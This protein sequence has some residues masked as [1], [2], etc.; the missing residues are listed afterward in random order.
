VLL[1]GGFGWKWEMLILGV[2]LGELFFRLLDLNG[3]F[4]MVI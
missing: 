2:S 1:L 4:V 3:D